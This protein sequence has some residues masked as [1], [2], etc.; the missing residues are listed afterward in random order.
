[1]SQ[2]MRHF[3][4]LRYSRR[5]LFGGI[6]TGVCYGAFAANSSV[7]LDSRPRQSAAA[8]AQ[9]TTKPVEPPPS[10]E[11]IRQISS[12]S[13]VGFATGLVV[14]VFSRTLV[15]LGGV[16]TACYHLA[17]S[18]GL[19]LPRFLNLPKYLVEKTPLLSHSTR[20]GWFVASFLLTFV[21]SAFVSL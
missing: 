8:P 7:R 5:L 1:M 4:A 12:G 21:L 13:V 10:P 18:Y 11:I 15:L 19:P 2:A 14:S 20:N 16:L 6:G 17:S 9:Y 3:A